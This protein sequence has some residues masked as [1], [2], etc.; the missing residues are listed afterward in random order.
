MSK[1]MDKLWTKAGDTIY[2]RFEVGHDVL[3]QEFECDDI[4]SAMRHK[5]CFLYPDQIQDRKVVCAGWFLGSYPKTFNSQEFLPAL[6]AHPPINGRDL[7]TRVQ[8]FR[9]QRTSAYSQ[10]IKAVHLYCRQ[11]EARAIR[12]ALNRIYGSEKNGGLPAGRDMKFIPSTTEPSLPPTASM[13]QKAKIA[14]SKQRRF[15]SCMVHTTVDSIMD[16]CS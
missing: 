10:K 14:A 16:M 4:R 6:Q 1:Y 13:I 3:R 15:L 5:E 2:I 9:L 11:H 8:D 12:A 7:K